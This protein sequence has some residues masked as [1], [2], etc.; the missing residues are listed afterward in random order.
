[1]KACPDF[2]QPFEPMLSDAIQQ[3]DIPENASEMTIFLLSYL[4]ERAIFKFYNEAVNKIE[5]PQAKRIL[6][7]LADEKKKYQS[8]L[9]EFYQHFALSQSLPNS[10]D[11]LVG[12]YKLPLDKLS[13]NADLLDV[14]QQ[15]MKVEKHSFDFYENAL[16]RCKNKSLQKLFKLFLECEKKYYYY[17]LTQFAN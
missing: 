12:K 15:T 1:M 9:N 13:R 2:I 10:I 11:K 4:R 5:L 17:L 7:A 16:E 8:I 14:F 6:K 3:G